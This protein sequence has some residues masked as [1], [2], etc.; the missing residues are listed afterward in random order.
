MRFALI[1]VLTLILQSLSGFA[2]SVENQSNDKIKEHINNLQ[3]DVKCSINTEFIIRNFNLSIAQLE[4]ANPSGED[5]SWIIAPMIHMA[6]G[7]EKDI[8]YQ[9]EELL[10]SGMN[11]TE[12]DDLINLIQNSMYPEY[13]EYYAKS[14]DIKNAKM[15]LLKLLK[16]QKDC[17]NWF[18][19]NVVPRLQSK[20]SEVNG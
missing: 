4:I 7:L 18:I 14:T 2:Q 8:E 20:E 17:E 3:T 10:K 13:V 15:F 6:I 9:K 16:D 5:K 11:K 12:I 1:A 19:T